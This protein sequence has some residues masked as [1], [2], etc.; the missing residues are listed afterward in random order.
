MTRAE[1]NSVISYKTRNFGSGYAYDPCLVRPPGEEI[2]CESMRDLRQTVS[3]GDYIKLTIYRRK[4]GE[5]REE[6]ETIEFRMEREAMYEE[7]IDQ[8]R[9][10]FIGQALHLT[11]L[12]RFG[13]RYEPSKPI[14]LPKGGVVVP[15]LSAT[16][17]GKDIKDRYVLDVYVD[18][19][20]V[21]QIMQEGNE[22]W[23]VQ[24][25]KQTYRNAVQATFQALALA[26]FYIF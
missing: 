9:A 6:M 11:D 24:G 18:K 5:K 12:E 7:E 14:D 21:T 22:E 17:A 20:Y 23:E 4:G 10:Q 26:D 13:I 2:Q 8:E 16:R 3:E 15:D 19:N 1:M 25:A